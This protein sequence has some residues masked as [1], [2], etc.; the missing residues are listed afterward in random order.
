MTEKEKVMYKIMDSIYNE[1]IPLVFKGTLITKLIL[2][3]HNSI[4][5]D[6]ETK[7]IDDELVR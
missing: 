1:D 5:L 7:D 6:R 2:L 4:K 3:E